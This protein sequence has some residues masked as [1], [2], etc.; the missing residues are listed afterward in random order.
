MKTEIKAVLFDMDGVLIDAKEW[1]FQALNDALSIFGFHISQ[2]EHLLRFDGLSTKKKLEILSNEL[3]LPRNLHGIISD[4]K[5]D[6]TLRIAALNCYP[7]TSHVVVIQRLRKLG[8]KVGLVTNSIRKT[9]E[10]MLTYA[11]IIQLLDVI[12]TNEDVSEQKPSPEGY[13]QAMSFL[14]VAPENCVIVEDGEYGI[15]AA[16][17][18]GA[19]VIRVN[20]PSEVNIDLFDSFV[21]K[22]TSI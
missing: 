19:F 18:S 12:V 15:K 8:I 11:G 2:D 20:S 4:V 7:T 16:K 17:A 5:Q 6:K 22:I 14:K 21:P 13:L 9:T 10:F 1:H 3:D